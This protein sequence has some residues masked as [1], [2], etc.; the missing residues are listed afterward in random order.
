M[1]SA[2]KWSI[3]SEVATKAT[4]PVVFLILARLLDP[5]SFG[6]FAFA[7]LTTTFAQIL[8][9]SGLSKALIQK[10]GPIDDAASVVLFVNVALGLVLYVLIIL[11]AHK[12]A[13]LFGDGRLEVVLMVQGLQM[14]IGP[15]ASV[16][17]ALLQR[18][19]DFKAIFRIRLMTILV[20]SAAALSMAASGY[21]YWALV[22]GVLI[23][24]TTRTVYLWFL[25]PWRPQW[26]FDPALARDLLRFGGW[27]F[28]EESLAWFIV[29]GDS[30]MAGLYLGSYE[31]GLYRTGGLI[32]SMILSTLLEP[33]VPVIF[34]A[35]SRTQGD[36][37]TFKKYV[38]MLTRLFSVVALPVASAVFLLREPLVDLLLGDKWQGLSPVIGGFAIATGLSYTASVFPP[39]FRASGRVKT[40]AK[41]R[42]ITV[43]YFL[44]SFLLCAPFGLMAL[45]YSRVAV[46]IFTLFL[47]GV[48]I[49]QSFHYPSADLIKNIASGLL[50]AVLIVVFVLVAGSSF[51]ALAGS[52]GRML[53]V[54]LLLLAC[55]SYLVLA[56]KDRQFFRQVLQASLRR[57]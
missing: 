43:C 7:T 31:L 51:G 15:A 52:W 9:D 39:A 4:T 1:V 3:L 20:G 30:A 8:W 55:A 32:V 50:W 53:L 34:S 12:I 49:R 27:I 18:Q 2:S 40:Y 14:V 10:E 35:L 41:L 42:I 23:G 21:G 17:N 6:I 38:D 33:L 28:L 5:N 36:E 16:Q 13:E 44:P 56:S 57:F 29:W 45:L 26:R 22:G 24:D 25:S 47:Y 48:F 19:M 11:S 46:T 54:G 37:R